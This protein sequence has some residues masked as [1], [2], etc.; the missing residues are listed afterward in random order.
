[1]FDL[2][3]LRV[4]QEVART[5]SFSAAAR[6]LGYTQPAI[7][8]QMRMLER[9]V[10]TA[11]AVR[12]GRTMRLTPAGETL[13][14]HAEA[15]FAANRAAEQDLAALVRGRAARVRLAA[16]P[17]ACA[18]LLPVVMA[19]LGQAEPLIDIR[20]SQAET[21]EVLAL[22]RAGA[23]D[24][25]VC[26]DYGDGQDDPSGLDGGRLARVPLLVDAVSVVLPAGHPLA[27]HDAVELAEL[28]GATFVLSSRRFEAL[29]K[30]AA[31]QAGFVPTVVSAADDYVS[32]Q[33]LVANGLGVALL[34]G[35]ALLAHC[36]PAVVAR[37]LRGWPPR[38]I[39]AVLWP[40]MGRVPA[41]AATLRALAA[42]AAALPPG[43]GGQL[44][45]R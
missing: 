36:G 2:R 33:A 29:L 4:L 37:P 8:Y 31:E 9:A 5:G 18:T 16:F 10:G 34:P 11:L 41:V 15:I 14:G 39:D 26:Y 6:V 45:A 22:L 40:D 12:V 17:S 24:V 21:P 25:G 19:A 23:V 38:R 3:H 44:S 35:L 7:T 13:A 20:L 1:M 27:G 30:T 43:A 42:A 28:A 32:M